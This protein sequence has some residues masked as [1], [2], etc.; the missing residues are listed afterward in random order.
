MEKFYHKSEISFIFP[1]SEIRQQVRCVHVLANPLPRPA[2]F[3][4]HFCFH[5]RCLPLSFPFD[6]FALTLEFP[7][8]RATRYIS[9]PSIVQGPRCFPRAFPISRNEGTR[10]TY[11]RSISQQELVSNYFSKGG[12]RRHIRGFWTEEK[13]TRVAS[14]LKNL[15]SPVFF[16]IKIHK[17]Q[18]SSI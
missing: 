13:E 2:N 7:S 10:S 3:A 1:R 15:H 5:L 4:P 6:H 12:E 11:R 16:V 9:D 14:S 8:S 17:K 18:P